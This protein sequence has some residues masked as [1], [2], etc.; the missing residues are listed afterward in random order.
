M[1]IL[2][3]IS[4]SVMAQVVP[5]AKG[6]TGLPVSG[7]LH[8]GLHYAETTQLG[9]GQDGQQMSIV[10]GDASFA[11]ISKRLPFSMQYGGG[12]GFVWAGPP[13]AGNVF[14][15]LSLSQGMAGR[16]WNLTASDNVSYTFETPTTGFSGVPGTGEPIGVPG[17]IT[18]P[19]QTILTVNTRSIDNFTT[20]GFGHR[21]D[22]LTTLNLGGSLGQMRFIDNNGQNMNTWTTNAG[23]TRRLNARNSFSG[24]YSF[25]RY[26]YGISAA[27]A[28]AAQINYSQVQ[29]AQFSF[30]RQWNPHIVTS[31]SVGP[32]W[33]SSSNNA[34]VPSSTRFS[35][36][37]SASDTFRV[38]TAS[39]TY[40]HGTTGG[41]GYMLG[42]ESDVVMANFGR[43][44]RFGKNLTVGV[45][46]SYMRTASLTAAEFEFAC[47]INN[48]ISICLV[49]LN[50]KPVTDAGFGGVQAT[51]KLSR[52]FNAFA[53]YT[54]ID[55]SSNLQL[56]VPNTP[57]SSNAIILNGLNQVISFGIGY[58]PREL[59]FKK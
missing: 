1:A 45:T 18:P 35:A 59:R 43:N 30:N 58:S 4:A 17:T 56:S 19:D 7:T 26:S 46:G 41:S 54:A 25:S 8:Y 23:V 36:N 34:I 14:Q 27:L 33:V 12:Y 44:F 16:T 24:Q 5:A 48:V 49:P 37:A 3:T 6:P 22:S 11:N 57:L 52:Y 50:Y 29:S 55:Q 9:G 20:L 31:A 32:Q 51:R 40:S 53:S 39:L 38:G 21:L 47:L 42:A 13:S 2:F 10:S 15:H 28:N